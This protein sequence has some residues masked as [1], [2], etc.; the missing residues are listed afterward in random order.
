MEH[1]DDVADLQVVVALQ[2]D[3]ALEAGLDFADIVLE[4]LERADLAGPQL[5]AVAEQARLRIARAPDDAFV[6]HATGDR[7]D[8]WHLERFTHGRGADARF[9]ERRVEQAGHRQLDLVGDV[10]DD[11]VVANVDLL[12]VSDVGGVT[13]GLHIEADDDRA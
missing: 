11:R 10:I 12:A 9:L 1:F 8:F 7:S 4:A 13:V 3:T 6:D 5:D 2:A